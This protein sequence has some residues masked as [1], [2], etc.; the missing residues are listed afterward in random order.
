MEDTEKIKEHRNYLLSVA[1]VAG[2]KVVKTKNL[3]ETIE[4]IRQFTNMT[5]KKL[6]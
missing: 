1:R 4:F 6:Q 5:L 2:F 3:S